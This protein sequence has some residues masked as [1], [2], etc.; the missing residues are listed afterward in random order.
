MTKKDRLNVADL[1]IF[2]ILVENFYLHPL[3]THTS[4]D[5]DIDAIVHVYTI[6]LNI[7]DI[8][9]VGNNIVILLN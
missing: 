9:L 8:I 2:S 3:Y 4:V 7:R 5:T 1:T 6:F